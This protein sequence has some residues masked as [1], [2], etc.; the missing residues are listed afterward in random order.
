MAYVKRNKPMDWTEAI[1]TVLTKAGG[2]PMHFKEITNEIIRKGY[3]STASSKNPENTVNSYLSRNKKL[4]KLEEPG[5]Y[6]LIGTPAPTP[7]TTVGGVAVAAS[8]CAS[9]RPCTS[10]S[11]GDSEYKCASNFVKDSSGLTDLEKNLLELIVNFRLPLVNGEVCFADILDKLEIEILDEEKSRLQSIDANLLEK[12]LEELNMKIARTTNDPMRS[13]SDGILQ[14]R[15]LS[16]AGEARL[17]LD[18]VSDGMVKFEY[19]ILGEFVSGSE[20]GSKPK[21][22][23]YLKSIE[24][25][26]QGYYESRWQVMAGVF[27]HEMFHAWNYFNAGRMK[28]SVMEIDEPMVESETLYFLKELEA[29]TRTHSPLLHGDVERVKVT[30]ERRVKEKQQAIGD[31]AAYGFGHYLYEKLSERDADSIKWIETYSKKSASINSVKKVKEA[32]IPIYPFQSEKQVMKWFERIIFDAKAT[33]KTAGKSATTKDGIDLSLRKLVLACIEMI[34]RKCF[35]AQELYAFAPIFKVCVPECKDL[36]N[37]LKQQLDELVNEGLLEALSD[38]CYR[39]LEGV[40]VKTKS[41]SPTSPTTP[42]STP[43]KS[44]SGRTKAPSVAFKVEFP[45]DKITYEE[46]TAVKTYIESLKHI[47]LSRVQSLGKMHGGYAL[48]S[49]VEDPDNSG[50]SLQHYEGG[51]YI[52]TKLGNEQKKGYLY[53]IANELGI[54]ISIRD[55]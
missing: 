40:G 49:D 17:L 31:V 48:V 8:S 42:V 51:K 29:F 37:A 7:H 32:L 30:R 22:V 34:G 46:E 50:K 43:T 5:V 47:G 23:I 10:Y 53:Q 4:F 41:P 16:V 9:A 1:V 52:Y 35:D 12:K 3:Y 54:K 6:K 39:K 44:K 25:S 45:D 55:I 24:K 11:R 20:I 15:M 21:I 27:I 36:E 19:P 26:I 13:N 2:G 33:S 18:G 28:R 14:E 38:D